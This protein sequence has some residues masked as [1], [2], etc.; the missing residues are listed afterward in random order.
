[1]IRKNKD[2]NPNNCPVTACL[3]KIGGK[4]KTV[5]LLMTIR[6]DLVFL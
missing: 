2:F 1:M 4:W 5:V 3:N 6:I